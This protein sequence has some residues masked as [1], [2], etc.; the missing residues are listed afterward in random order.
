MRAEKAIKQVREAICQPARHEEGASASETLSSLH[1]L[2]CSSTGQARRRIRQGIDTIR[3]ALQTREQWDNRPEIRDELLHILRDSEKKRKALEAAQTTVQ[4]CLELARTEDPFASPC[5]KAAACIV[6]SAKRAG[7]SIVEEPAANGKGP[8]VTVCG[9]TFLA[10]F[11]LHPGDHRASVKFRDIE[12]D[13]TEGPSNS[14]VDEDFA[15]LVANG[16]FQSLERAFRSLVQ[17]EE[18]D[19]ALGNNIPLRK[20]LRAFEND[21]ISM[22]VAEGSF[23]PADRLTKGHGISIRGAHGLR[24]VY[25]N[26]RNALLSA[27]DA[28]EERRLVVGPSGPSPIPRHNMPPQF[29][30]ATPHSVAARAQYILV[31]DKPIAITLKMAQ[32]LERIASSRTKD[33]QYAAQGG[34]PS[35]SLKRLKE[36]DPFAGQ[37]PSYSGSLRESSDAGQLKVLPGHIDHFPSLQVLLAPDVFAPEVSDDDVEEDANKGATPGAINSAGM[38]NMSLGG[39][40]VEKV[41]S[42]KTNKRKRVSQKQKS[43]YIHGVPLPNGQYVSL[44]HNASS[45]VPGVTITKVPVSE[46]GD[47]SKVFS[48]LRQQIAFNELF[49][50][51]YSSP[52]MA[53]ESTPLIRELV[54]VGISDAPE[55]MHFGVYDA[56]LDDFIGVGIQIG[57]DGSFSVKLSGTKRAAHPCTDQ[58]ATSILCETRSVPL[59]IQAINQI[60][61]PHQSLH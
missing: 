28:P 21:V 61:M 4:K 56:R 6:A 39:S 34:A 33:V 54:E 7:A 60:S 37:F 46:P 22:Q 59:T 17:L 43:E 29:Q 30:F 32:K 58:K 26:E 31:L 25:A 8:L 20:G 23:T 12:A 55:Y 40:M 13:G 38:S 35:Q 14:V 42:T 51:C 15:R 11:H 53:V 45:L 52:N 2:A 41:G 57:V 9:P 36:E 1:P 24:I 47:L 19:A 48:I 50:S 44:T 5:A 10:D 49:E 27:E 18:L 3:T 16:E